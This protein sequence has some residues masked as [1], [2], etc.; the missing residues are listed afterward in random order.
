SAAGTTAVVTGLSPN[1]T[2]AF[3]VRAKDT[4][5]NLSAASAPVN[6]TTLNPADDTTPP[7]VPGS[8]RSTDRTATSVG[9]AW[10]ASTDANGIAGYDTY[11][12]GVL[13]TSVTGTT[14]NVTGLSPLTA[15]TFTVRARDG[16]DNQSAVSNAV[17]VTTDD[18]VGAGNYAKVGY[19]VQWGIYGRQYF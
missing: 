7:S 17:V 8:L 4:R 3:T 9:L 14:A 5:G 19:F 10:N 12:G 11:V 16:Y 1:T 13:K 6:G 15:Y 18:V 2:Y